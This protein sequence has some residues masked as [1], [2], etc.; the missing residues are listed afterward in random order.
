MKKIIVVLD[1]VAD[2]PQLALDGKTPLEYAKTPNLDHIAKHAALGC[3]KTIPKGLEVG[4]AVANLNLLG[5]NPAECYNGRAVIEGAGVGLATDAESM[6]IRCNFVTLEGGD[7]ENSH[8]KSYSADD[9]PTEQ[10]QKL[11]DLLNEKL[12]DQP[13]ELINTGSF[14]N[15][16]AIHGKKDFYGKVS[17]MPAH[18]IIGKPICENFPQGELGQMFTDYLKRAYEVLKGNGTKANGIWF[19]G[20]SIAP[21]IKNPGTNKIVLAE[22]ILMCGITNIAGIDTITLDEF[23]PFPEF[24]TLKAQRAAK[25]INEKY[26]EAYVHIQK[27]D[28]LSHELK[29]VEKAQAVEQ[30]D[31]Y[32]FD[33]FLE[34][35]LGPYH[36]IVVSDHFT[37][38]DDGSHG[39]EA[40]PF[41]LYCSGEE[42]TKHQLRWTEENAR[43]FGFEVT[44]QELHVLLN[45]EG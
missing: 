29:P 39:G 26:D 18:D 24:L 11:T 38:S 37:F 21:T 42:E 27:P 17:F 16:L 41:M 14:R 3:V 43:S 28:D 13:F 19:W 9:I 15:I 2:R 7:F 25:A 8:I 1:G 32:F 33:P 45:F 5:F 35:L 31:K 4:S 22:T 6:Y 10:S 34:N 40:A 30:I 23:L 20:D 36:L 44:P 12:F